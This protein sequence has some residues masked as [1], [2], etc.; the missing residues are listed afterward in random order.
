MKISIPAFALLL[1]QLLLTGEA[2]GADR[3]KLDVDSETL[4]GI[5]LQRIEQEPTLPR[6]LALLE[7]YVVEYPKTT[8]VPW[9]YEQLLSIYMEASQWD[10]VIATADGMLGADPNDVESPYDALKAAEAQSNPELMT[11]YAELAWDNASHELQSPKPSDPDD[12]PD[13]TK[14]MTFDQEALDYSEYALAT[15]AAAQTN[16]L[17]R[18]EVVLVLQERNPKSKFL[19]IAKKPTVIELATLNPQK[20]IQLAEEGLVKDPDNVDF[21]MTVADHDM[22]LEKNLP[23][24]LTYSLHILELVEGKPQPS[25]I[26]QAEWEKK[27]AKFT[28][29]ASWLAGVVY[30]KQ[31]RYGL[32]DRYLRVALNYIH[33]D[34]HLLAAA[35]FY[36][37]YANYAL[38][39]ELADKGRAID[40]LK[41]SKQCVDMD[42]P[43][44]SLALKNLE[45]LRNDYN[46]E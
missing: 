40:A 17:K 12:L 11:K 38:A 46:L 37:G 35:Y 24:V 26:T 14:R 43:F 30:G 41:F 10:R 27:K 45:A 39:G 33:G 34:Q 20:A 42:S 23:R 22:S 18:A 31:G 25:D 2:L 28:G 3:H 44:R 15:L 5:L 6:K 13:W 1:T 9:V 32:S 19:A 21:L 36:L 29:W 16:D 8:S 4:D 7:K